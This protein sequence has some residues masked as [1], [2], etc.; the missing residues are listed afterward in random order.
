MSPWEGS[1][2]QVGKGVTVW[3][4]SHTQCSETRGCVTPGPGIWYP[5]DSEASP[6]GDGERR[7]EKA[8]C[9]EQSPSPPLASFS[10]FI[11][12]QVY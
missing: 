3:G 2:G 7:L 10:P 8:M 4:Q 11:T 5:G 9:C 1:G 6:E 12:K